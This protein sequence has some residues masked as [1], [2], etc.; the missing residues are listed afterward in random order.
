MRNLDESINN[1]NEHYLELL[2]NLNRVFDINLEMLKNNHFDTA[3]YGECL[4]V[5]D[6]INAFEVTIKESSIFTIARFQPAASNLRLLIMLIDSS[7][8]LERMGDILKSNLLYIKDIEK[9]SPDILFHL[10][11]TLYPMVL[12]IKNIYEGYISAVI[13]QDEKTLFSLIPLDEEVN[14]LTVENIKIITETMKNNP[15]Y[16]EGGTKLIILTKKFERFSDHIIH[17]VYDLIY[18]LKGKNMRKLELI[19]ENKF[20]D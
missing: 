20:K 15:D 9:T 7:R 5:E 4:V 12:K 11:D 16:I 8:L 3:L 2:K 14:E 10:K 1:L 18:I 19:E 13:N 6:I 17:L